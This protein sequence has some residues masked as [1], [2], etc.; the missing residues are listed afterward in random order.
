VLFPATGESLVYAAQ[1][2]TLTRIEF[3]NGDS[4]KSHEGWESV[5]EQA[6]E[7]DNQLAYD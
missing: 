6:Q 1:T 7:K 2:A 4:V 5:V 3:V